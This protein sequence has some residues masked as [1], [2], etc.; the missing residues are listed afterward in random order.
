ME[1]VSRASA[2]V[3]LG[4]VERNCARLAGELAEGVELCAVVKADGYGHGA[5]ECVAAALAGGAGRLAVATALEAVEIRD[6]LPDARL[7]VLGALS[8]GELELVLGTGAELTVWHQGFLEL[9]AARARALGVRPRIHVKADTGMGR[10]GERDPEAA[11]ALLDRAAAEPA[12]ELEAFWTH[13][14]TADEPGSELF[15]E[16]LSRFE[17]LAERARSAHP[18]ILVHAANSAATLAEPAAHFDMVRCGV[19]VYGLDPFGRS[20]SEQGLSPAL[21]LRSYVAD[22]K[23]FEAGASA[24]YGATWQAPEETSVGVVPIG[25]GDGVR[26]ALGNNGDVLAG[27]RRHPIVG[28]ISMDNLTVDLG[29]EPVVAPGDPVVVIGPQDDDEITAEQLAAALGTINYEITC[30]ISARVPREYVR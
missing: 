3:D 11:I 20:A 27:G 8:A 21:S 24:G 25:Y 23:R 4:A 9:V 29:R 12:V 30:G 17:A 5:T 13:F 19:A 15:A 28:T 26:R 7:L 6:A 22:V 18:G 16:Q 2:V 14:A 10:L 1:T